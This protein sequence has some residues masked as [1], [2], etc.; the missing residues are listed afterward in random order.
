MAAELQSLLDKIQSE[1]IAKAEAGAKQILEDAREQAEKLI[2]EAKSE[3]EASRKR[4]AAEAEQFRERAEQAVRQAARDVLLGVREALDQTL[5]R[6]FLGQIGKTLDPEFLKTLIA[7]TVR[8]YVQSSGGQVEVLVPAEQL[9]VLRDHVLK[10]VQGK[11]R[12][13]LTVRADDDLD[14]GFSVRVAEGRVEHDFSAGAI[15]GAMAGLL[16]PSLAKLLDDA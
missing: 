8:A 13:G 3:Q 12:E 6:V 1:G 4:A 16:R 14:G 7:D 9:E 10:A 11:A 15:Q 5:Q 2:A